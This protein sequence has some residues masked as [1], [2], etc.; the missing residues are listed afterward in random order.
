M[1]VAH[2]KTLIVS[3]LMARVLFLSSMPFFARA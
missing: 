2:M 3:E 1:I